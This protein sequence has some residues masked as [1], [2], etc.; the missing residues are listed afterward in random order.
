MNRGSG[1]ESVMP[2]GVTACFNE[3]PIH[4]SGKFESDPPVLLH[5]LAS[6]RPRF[7]NRGSPPRSA[8]GAI[9]ARCFN[10]API[11]ESGKSPPGYPT[12]RSF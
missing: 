3:A 4:E 5:L 7:M 1:M 8:A 9:T 6:M 10:E 11:H 12:S 2:E